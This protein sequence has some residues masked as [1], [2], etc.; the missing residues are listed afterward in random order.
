M[1]RANDTLYVFP[2]N[3]YLKSLESSSYLDE[4]ICGALQF[5]VIDIKAN[6]NTQSTVFITNV[7]LQ[8]ERSVINPQPLP[9]VYGDS[10]IL[11]TLF[12]HNNGWGNMK[13]CTLR[14]NLVPYD[15]HDFEW[16]NSFKE[17]SEPYRFTKQIGD[18][19]DEYQLS[20][21]HELAACGVDTHIIGIF[22]KAIENR[23]FDQ[24]PNEEQLER[25][26]GIFKNNIDAGV[27]GEIQYIWETI[28]NTEVTTTT[29][30]VTSVHF[31]YGESGDGV[32][33]SHYVGNSSNDYDG[34][35]FVD[36]IDYDLIIPVAQALEPGQVDRFSVKIGAKKSSKHTFRVILEKSDGSY[37]NI[38]CV[39]SL[40]LYA[41]KTFIDPEYFE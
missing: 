6:N 18:I 37:V 20:I 39:V 17:I 5:P 36:S 23:R 21:L 31:L 35:L 13:N 24:R 29:E 30:Y 8:V 28:D 25:A 38:P 10:T 2:R 40:D 1:S 9:S 7:I 19:T 27:V 3:K 11:F 22:N 4:Y 14:F 33:A 12:I 15:Y 34:E 26:R 41:P 32:S 16:E